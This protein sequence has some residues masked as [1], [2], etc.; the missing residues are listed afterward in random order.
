MMRK[1]ILVAAMTVGLL[2][3]STAAAFAGGGG[4]GNSQGQCVVSS[5]STCT[6]SH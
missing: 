2:F 3:G 6:H 5:G 4:P 1:M